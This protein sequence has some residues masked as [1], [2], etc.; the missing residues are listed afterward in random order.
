MTLPVTESLCALLETSI[1]IPKDTAGSVFSVVS[2][3]QMLSVSVLKYIF[4]VS[5]FAHEPQFSNQSLLKC[6]K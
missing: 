6:Q 3:L 2:K 4:T 1:V 5:L